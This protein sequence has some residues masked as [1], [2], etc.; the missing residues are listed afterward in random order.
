MSEEEEATR[1][2]F[3]KKQEDFLAETARLH[4][5]LIN[6]R[7]ALAE[8]IENKGRVIELEGLAFER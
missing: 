7:K 4:E 8:A 3:K 1:A 6:E 2:D 5:A